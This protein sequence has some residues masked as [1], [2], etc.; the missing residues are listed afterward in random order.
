[1]Q[2]MAFDDEILIHAR[3]FIAERIAAGCP[4]T[5]EEALEFTSHAF[6]ISLSPDA[7]RSKLGSRHKLLLLT[8][9]K[10]LGCNSFS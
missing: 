8:C 6:G 2:P 1:M 3:Q 10:G 5:T 4:A 9:T 7:L